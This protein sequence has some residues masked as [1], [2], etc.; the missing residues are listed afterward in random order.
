[1]YFGYESGPSISYIN[2]GGCPLLL[3]CGHEVG[4]VL[5]PDIVS[6]A[7][8]VDVLCRS[9]VPLEKIYPVWVWFA[10]DVDRV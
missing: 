4:E 6:I 10:R 7:L 5:D 1:M 3:L 2:G 8:F 9:R